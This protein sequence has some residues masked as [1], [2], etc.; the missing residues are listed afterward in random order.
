[1]WLWFQEIDVKA[2]GGCVVYMG[3]MARDFLV[4][5]DWY[6]ALFPRI[7]VPIQKLIVANLKEYGPTIKDQ[8]VEE[9]QKEEEA[10]YVS[11]L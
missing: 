10:R 6:G 9:Q 11:V 8:Y 2:G 7:P 3:D 1:M 5:L 4:K